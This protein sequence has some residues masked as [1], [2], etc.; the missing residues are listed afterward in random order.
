MYCRKWGDIHVRYEVEAAAALETL[1]L[2]LNK[3]HIKNDEIREKANFAYP[4]YSI[5][6]RREIAAGIVS[7][8]NK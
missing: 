1:R 4:V 6:K 8:L 5:N 2:H 7:V 3:E